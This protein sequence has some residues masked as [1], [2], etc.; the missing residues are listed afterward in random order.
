MCIY[1]L[2]VL[3]YAVTCAA[4]IQS[5]DA[6]GCRQKTCSSMKNFC[7]HGSLVKLESLMLMPRLFRPQFIMDSYSDFDI[8]MTG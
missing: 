3:L 1:C 6:G 8:M 2:V 7:Q 4:L 5:I